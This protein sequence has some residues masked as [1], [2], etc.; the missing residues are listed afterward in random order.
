MHARHAYSAPLRQAPCEKA[1]ICQGD[2]LLSRPPRLP[3]SLLLRTHLLSLLA[4]WPALSLL[5]ARTLRTPNGRRW[6]PAGVRQQAA[7]EKSRNERNTRCEPWINMT[8][9]TC[10]RHLARGQ[11][12][13]CFQCRPKTPMGIALVIGFFTCARDRLC[14]PEVLIEPY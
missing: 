8:L 10:V 3:F 14:T 12:R 4:K 6:L 7:D 5:P 9:F 2:F 1:A 13:D 11:L